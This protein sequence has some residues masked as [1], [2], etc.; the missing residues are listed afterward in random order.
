M[1]IANFVFRRAAIY[2][3]RRRIPTRIGCESLH[4]Q[5]SLGTACPATARRLAGILTHESD[6]VF[7]AM[8]LDGLSREAARQWLEQVVRDEMARIE[9]R[10]RA[11]SDSRET[12]YARMNAEEDRAM[13]HALRLLARDGVSAELGDEEKQEL[14]SEGVP[15]SSFERVEAYLSQAA[16]E[17]LAPSVE[18]KIQNGI[19]AITG[20]A[21]PSAHDFLDARTIYLRGRA[22]VYLNASQRRDPALAEALK[23]AEALEQGGSEPTTPVTQETE[24]AFDPAIAAIADRLTTKKIKLGRATEKTAYQIRNTAALL[25][26]ATGVTDIRRLKQSDIAVFCDVMSRLP[27]AYRKSPKEKLVPLADI[28]AAA[29]ETSVKVGLSPATVNRNL[30][31]VAQIVKHANAEGLPTQGSIDVKDLRESDMEDDQD[32]VPPFERSDIRKLF[33]GSIWSGCRSSARRTSPGAL[34]IKDGLYW[35][36][37][38]AAYTGARR[39]E[40]AGLRRSDIINEDG[41]WAFE[42]TFTEVR[43]LKNLQSKR[44]VPIH[45]HLIELGFLKHIAKV[46]TGRI[47]PELKRKSARAN[48]GDHI[49]YN[50]RAMLDKQLGPTAREKRFHSFRHYVIDELRFKQRVE[51]LTRHHILG[52]LVDSTEDRIYGKRTPLPIM[53]QAVD[54]LPRLF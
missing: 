18:R 35:I 6:E 4:L 23:V 52:H 16:G 2:T 54:A 53:K 43:R 49:H 47:F 36:P 19:S 39:E 24:P 17:V 38:I 22:A 20:D 40:I 33:E 50:F 25:V 27:P 29:A 9:R 14:V 41:V 8:A 44:K 42:F 12:G 15:K 26:E 11:Q 48:L 37:M 31:F 34:V 3:W 5:V 21:L 28:I 13:G 32:K 51:K 7:E 1:G 46:E 30:G 45:E 10:K